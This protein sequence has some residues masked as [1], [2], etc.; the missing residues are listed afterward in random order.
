MRFAVHSTA[1]I[2]EDANETNN[3]AT[4]TRLSCFEFLPVIY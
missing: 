2:A 3:D 4:N 1:T